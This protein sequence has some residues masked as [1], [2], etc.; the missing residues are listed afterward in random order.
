MGV[1]V[2]RAPVS[3]RSPEPPQS[4]VT[5]PIV[6][7]STA[8]SKSSFVISYGVLFLYSVLFCS[9]FYKLHPFHQFLFLYLEKVCILLFCPECRLPTA[10]I[11]QGLALRLNISTASSFDLAKDPAS[12]TYRLYKHLTGWLI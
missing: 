11:F 6:C 7:W 10:L 12:S 5:G 4:L 9:T 3:T 2:P 1:A 8:I